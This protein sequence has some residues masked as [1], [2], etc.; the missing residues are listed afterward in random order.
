MLAVT[1]YVLGRVL[2]PRPGGAV[3]RWAIPAALG[4]AAAAHLGL[5]LGFA[6]L[7]KP[8]PV[9]LALA[10]VHLLGLRVWRELPRE[11]GELFRRSR[12]RWWL[13]GAVVL[14][15]LTVLV[16]YPPTSFDGTLYHL[17]FAKAFA[18]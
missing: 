11:A 10:G 3:E 2:A 15:P 16:F 17:P 4:I 13:A 9:L 12:P 18:T 1:A 7:L 14:L 8:V 5:L 6:G